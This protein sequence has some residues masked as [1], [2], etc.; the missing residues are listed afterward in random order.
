MTAPVGWG[1]LRRLGAIAI[2]V[3][4]LLTAVAA[5]AASSD[6]TPT[7]QL[8]RYYTR[9]FDRSFKADLYE[10]MP[11]VP[12]VLVFGGSRSLRMQPDTIKARTRLPAFNFGFHNGRPE[13]AWAVT[14]W[15]LDMHPEKPPTVIWCV[16]ATTFVDVPMHPGL[17]VDERLSQALDPA[18][19]EAKMAWAMRQPKR[20]LLSGRRYGYD[21]MLW[22]NTYDRRR[23]AGRTLQ[24]ALD[25]YLNAKMLAKAGNRKIPRNTRSMTYFKRTIRLLN[26]HGIRPLIVI[27]PYHPRVLKAFYSVGWGVKE[28]WLRNYLSN[29]SKRLNFRVVNCLRISSFGGSPDGFYDGSHLTAGN[30]RRLLRYCIARAPGCFR[31]PTYTPSPSPSPSASPGSGSPS[32]A[33]GQAP[34]PYMPVPEDTSA[35]ADYLE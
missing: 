20:N 21:G 22:W 34:P 31:V 6:S 16:Q 15:V 3:V 25:G 9:G 8:K 19:V 14:D 24:Q 26:S 33:P 7:W 2:G 18:L 23:K 30:S 10:E 5:G 13:D 4:C 29:L 27:M 1:W 32:P 17:I 28:R 11:R 35:P 12:R